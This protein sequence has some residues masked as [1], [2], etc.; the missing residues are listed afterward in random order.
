MV[1][2]VRKSRFDVQCLSHIHHSSLCTLS[3]C[4]MCA[5]ACESPKRTL[6]RASLGPF[7]P[8]GVHLR[9]VRGRFA[10]RKQSTTPRQSRLPLRSPCSSQKQ[11]RSRAPFF[12]LTWIKNARLLQEDS[13]SRSLFCADGKAW[14]S[15]GSLERMHRMKNSVSGSFVQAS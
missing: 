2:S 1:L 7:A 8:N 10:T 4:D 11:S 9:S 15:K 14:R 13:S 3:L 5:C 12:E 6:S